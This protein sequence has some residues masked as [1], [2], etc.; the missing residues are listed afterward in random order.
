MLLAPG[1]IS[2]RIRWGGREISRTDYKYII[3]DYITYSFLIV[4]FDYAFMFFTYAERSVS[5]S[6]K[7]TAFD[8][9]IYHASFVFKYSF[10]ALVIAL[11]LP[12]IIS[13]L[14]EKLQKK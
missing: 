7:N 6:L 10:L 5:F 11:I 8:S 3:C 4:L 1:L 13:K 9:N 14:N 12:R 2:L